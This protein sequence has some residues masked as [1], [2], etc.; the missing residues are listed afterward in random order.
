MV[1]AT[2]VTGQLC[3]TAVLPRRDAVPPGCTSKEPKRSP[4]NQPEPWEAVV[5]G[6]PAGHHVVAVL[7]DARRHFCCTVIHFAHQIQ[8]LP[9]DAGIQGAVVRNQAGAVRALLLRL[10]SLLPYLSFSRVQ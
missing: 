6:I 10:P 1:W 7:D 4:A 8:A 3:L 2:A 9:A 5:E